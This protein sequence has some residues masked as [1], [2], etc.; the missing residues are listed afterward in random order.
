LILDSEGNK[1]LAKY[2]GDKTTLEK[3]KFERKIFEKTKKS[4]SDIL[5]FEG[6][7]VVYRSVVDLFIYFTCGLD[8]NEIILANILGV[9]VESLNSLF[10]F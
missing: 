7:I 4:T 1:L 2:Y 10:K 8:E 5:L 9:F 3:Q 6:Q